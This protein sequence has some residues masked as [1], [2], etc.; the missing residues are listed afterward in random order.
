MFSGR[1]S[2]SR[3][4]NA[5]FMVVVSE[6]KAT[7]SISQGNEASFLVV[8]QENKATW[9]VFRIFLN[10][11]RQHVGE[12]KATWNLSTRQ[13][14]WVGNF[15]GHRST[16]VGSKACNQVIVHKINATCYRNQGYMSCFQDVDR[17]AKATM[18]V[19]W[20]S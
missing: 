18:Q 20:S 3:G 16:N 13:R 15:Q 2:S 6:N 17:A 1:R 8:V 4:N 5:S 7:C 10:I 12:I 14:V 11:S 9:L 19:L